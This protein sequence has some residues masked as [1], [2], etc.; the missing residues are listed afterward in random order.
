M[1]R[2]RGLLMALAPAALLLPLVALALPDT[3]RIPRAKEHRP[4]APA[5]RALFSHR[6]HEPLRCYQCHPSPFPQALAPFTHADMD[7]GLFCGA[8]HEGRRAQAISAY[9]CESCHVP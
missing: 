2:V 4:G 9:R 6:A 1:E 3:V 5:A 7:R 8:C